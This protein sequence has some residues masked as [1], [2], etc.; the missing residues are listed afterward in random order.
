M[1]VATGTKY[2][3]I[4]TQNIFSY[5]INGNIN[6]TSGIS[7]FGFSG[8]NGNLNLF[9]FKTGKIYDIN[10][11]HVWSYNPSE[12][13]LI[14]GNINSGDHNYYINNNIVC[15]TSPKQ[16]NFYNYLYINSQNSQID[17]DIGLYGNQSPNYSIQ[18]P[19]KNIIGDD[20]TGYIFNK[21]N[22]IK[23]SFQFFTGNV[24]GEESIY[25]LKNIYSG[26]IS[27][28]NSGQFLL[29][30]NS[31][32]DP[33]FY[34][35]GV[36]QL[37][38]LNTTLLFN[39]N[40]GEVNTSFDIAVE[41]RPFYFIDFVQIF[42]GIT[43]DNYFVY[44]YDVRTKSPI[45]QNVLVLLSNYTGHTGDLY[46]TG[47][48]SYGQSS[49]IAS[50]FIYGYDYISGIS[51]GIGISFDVDYSGN[52][53]SGNFTGY[54][55]QYQ[56]ATG[57]CY[58]YY[59]LPILGGTG[60][61]PAMPGTLIGGTGYVNENN[62]SFQNYFI[63][64]SRN[65]T[66]R[67][68]GL[69]TGY[70]YDLIQTGTG[71]MNLIN[72]TIN[73]FTGNNYINNVNFSW[74]SNEIYP[75]FE[76][77]NFNST[78]QIYGITGSGI[79]LLFIDTMSGIGNNISVNTLQNTGYLTSKLFNLTPSDI[80][81]NISGNVFGSE[82]V[83]NLIYVFGNDQSVTWGTTPDI[84][85]GFLGFELKNFNPLD[86]GIVTYYEIDLNKNFSN[87][88]YLPEIF[89]LQ[90]STNFLNWTDM[91]TRSG[92]DFYE[93][94]TNVFQVTGTGN[95]NYLRLLINSGSLLPHISSNILNEYPYGLSINKINFYKTL[96]SV[97]GFYQNFIPTNLT[98]NSGLFSNDS[99]NDLWQA[100]QLDKDTYP[101]IEI[102]GGIL[103]YQSPAIHY[104][105]SSTGLVL[106]PN[107]VGYKFYKT[108][109]LSSSRPVYSDTTNAYI[110]SN[111][112]SVNWRIGTG[113][114]SVGNQTS[115]FA[116]SSNVTTPP[117][118]GLYIP[119]N[120]TSATRY[121][122]NINLS[123]YLTLTG[124]YIS[125][126]SGYR[127][128]KLTI[129]A[130]MSGTG[131]TTFYST[132]V[133]SSIIS[134]LFQTGILITGGDTGYQYFRFNFTGGWNLDSI[135]PINCYTGWQI[136]N[137][138]SPTNSWTSI[139]MIKNGQIQ[140]AVGKN[141]SGQFSS[142][143]T[144]TVYIS[145][146]FGQTWSGSRFAPRTTSDA[147]TGPSNA[148]SLAVQLNSIAID[149]NTGRYALICRDG[150]LYNVTQFDLGSFTNPDSYCTYLS[151]NS[152]ISFSKVKNASAVDFSGAW[153][154][155]AMSHD[156]K[157]MM[158]VGI[159]DTDVTQTA[160]ISR[161][162]G[163]ATTWIQATGAYGQDLTSLN[164]YVNLTLD[165]SRSYNA[166]TMSSGGNVIYVGEYPGY[167][168]RSINTGYSWLNL[169]NPISTYWS[170]ISTSYNGQYV[171]AIG[172][173]GIWVSSNSGDTWYNPLGANPWKSISLSSGGQYQIAV[174]D[175]ITSY[176]S[177]DFGTTWISIT[178]LNTSTGYYASN[179]SSDGKYQTVGLKSG[180]LYNNCTFGQDY[181]VQQIRV[182]YAN[183]YSP[184][185]L[186]YTIGDIT[187]HGTMLTKSFGSGVGSLSS[188]TG[189]AY[190]PAVFYQTGLFT[191]Q[192]DSEGSLFIDELNV[193][194]TGN[195]GKVFTNIITGV[196]NA[197]GIVYFNTGFLTEGDSISINKYPFTYI[198]GEP[199][200]N[201][202]FNSLSGLINTLNSGA[203]GGLDDATL[204]YNI[205]VTGYVF[206]NNSGIVLYSCSYSGE[207]GNALTL[208][209]NVQ[210]LSAMTIPHRYFRSGENLRYKVTNWGGYFTGNFNGL[211]VENTGI[212]TIQYP[213]EDFYTIYT[214]LIFE[215]NFDRN[216][217]LT[218]TPF[219]EGNILNTGLSVN[220]PY[221]SLSKTFS[222]NFN[223]EKNLFGY[224]G[225]SG[226]NIQFSKRNLILSTDG[227]TNNPIST[228]N[229]AKYVISGNKFLFTGFLKG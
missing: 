95:Y 73:Y 152:G 83:D 221:Y 218:I 71:L 59:N 98:I 211:S 199:P 171:T 158:A 180:K 77:E 125:F 224:V 154:K 216:W 90:G 37:N 31:D 103:G 162:T 166:L 215:N 30:Y 66:G 130:S 181:Q 165:N 13:F 132:D 109:G 116:L 225:Y 24:V 57:I 217:Q 33:N 69:L 153:T 138:T 208:I 78:Y 219:S 201:Y 121:L 52:Y 173:D 25:T 112:A 169:N 167:I 91:D 42:S 133:T 75:G 168:W 2:R 140:F 45:N 48:L 177:N 206:P 41:A 182:K 101:Y 86:S 67:Q 223:I 160:I 156:A 27:G 61:A 81:E 179:I 32:L 3:S 108:T 9:T 87:Y 96:K 46:Y 40:F 18:F 6:N 197:T 120:V 147:A 17:L 176:R 139:S 188:I 100:T 227:D 19:F 193:A 205:G 175:A 104:V 88:K 76:L 63:Y 26:F 170:D 195:I 187:G 1:I 111:S 145:R 68:T 146:D 10:N 210:N 44:N 80:S 12:D 107:L 204:Q 229:I 62:A 50:G 209:R 135:S 191:G 43:G 213:P 110:I 222:G 94:Y 28:T 23:L 141:F 178:G 47:F 89:K 190:Q 51:T 114:T 102:T 148:H 11:Q 214:G 183:L 53:V 56:A 200:S 7:S 212:Y 14:S 4:S 119:T 85:T 82:S 74:S 196:R 143:A 21:S 8:D 126:E 185:N 15:L 137:T 106:S 105:V 150:T 35:S 38:N 84:S 157:I 55:Q 72:S 128:N 207:D 115:R 220:L 64:G 164:N 174:G 226:L 118:T 117:I 34:S 161:N 172:V 36:V 198:T 155:V 113:I 54:R 49:G 22:N 129:E 149:K 163:A 189:Q 144:G 134:G 202:Y 184:S 127:P 39:T 122:G 228:G 131:Y 16:N 159:Y 194:G 79:Q 58:Y 60:L 29:K 124:F 136:N 142:P 20:I 203:S 97:S 70:W 192:T 93:P 5:A 123:D 151:T 92:I 65:I 99:S 186:N